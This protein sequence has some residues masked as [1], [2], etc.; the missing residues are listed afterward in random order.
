MLFFT[1]LE[2][3]VKK[4]LP[5]VQRNSSMLQNCIYVYGNGTVHHLS[6]V[7]TTCFDWLCGGIASNKSACMIYQRNCKSN[8]SKKGIICD[9]IEPFLLVQEM[10]SLNLIKRMWMISHYSIFIKS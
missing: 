7:N 3:L 8:E 2:M 4:L 1:P 6:L 10:F 9:L 5:C